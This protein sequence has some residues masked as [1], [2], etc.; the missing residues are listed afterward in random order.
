[1]A[2]LDTIMLLIVDHHAAIGGGED[3]LLLS[4]T[5]HM[6]TVLLRNSLCY[7]FFY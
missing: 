4:C 7:F 1:M 2:S 6:F 5:G 3:P